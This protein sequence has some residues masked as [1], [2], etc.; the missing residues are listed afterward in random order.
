MNETIVVLVLSA[1]AGGFG[2]IVGIGGGLVIVPVLTVL[3]GVP[4]KLAIAASLVGV[5]ATSIAASSRYLAQDL[6][7]RRLG[8]LLLLATVTGG[9]AGG[10][11]A[12]L[13][14][15]RTLSGL[16]AVVLVAVAIRML[17]RARRPGQVSPVVATSGGFVSTFRDPLTGA[18]VEY[19]ARRVGLGMAISV[20]AGSVSGLLG[21][22]GGIINV[23]TMN[24]LMQVPIRV[25]VTT[26]TYMLAATA[27][28]S[29]VIY[30][31]RGQLSPLVAA[32]VALGV[33]LGA[34]VGVRLAG[35]LPD[36]GLRLAF[37]GVALF[38][39]VQMVQKAVSP[40]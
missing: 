8:L 26:S 27:V 23:P 2:S 6:A 1:L 24:V 38:F 30:A 10:I 7:D 18:V 33:F 22:G 29:S 14:D 35:R 16:F 31:A 28:A 39:A 9:L 20:V 19:Q 13:L 40:G 11:T 12:G 34:Q 3:V 17:P 21:V 25:A 4:V 37:V 36:N 15:G 32:P 5:V